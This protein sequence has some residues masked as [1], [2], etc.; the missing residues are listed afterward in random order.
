MDEREAITGLL[1]R[2]HAKHAHRRRQNGLGALQCLGCG[3]TACRAETLV[4]LHAFCARRACQLGFHLSER[5]MLSVDPPVGGK[6]VAPPP[7]VE[8][9]W[10]DYI[11]D[12][13]ICLI[14]LQAFDWAL[15]SVADYDALMA[16]RAVSQRFAR[17]IDDC[18][19]PQLWRLDGSVIPKLSLDALMR[20]RGLRT[21]EYQGNYAGDADEQARLFA[22][23]PA[24]TD[25][26]LAIYG[27]DFGSREPNL[28]ALPP[29]LQRLSLVH[30]TKNAGA[31]AAIQGLAGQLIALRLYDCP[32]MSGTALAGQSALR[33]LVLHG[34]QAPLD[35]GPCVA[36]ETL[37]ATP[38]GGA[39]LET[40]S[41]TLTRLWLSTGQRAMPVDDAWIAAL[42][43][44]RHLYFSGISLTDAGLS[45]LVNLET[46]MLV[47]CPGVTGAS[48]S[49]LTRLSALSLEECHGAHDMTVEQAAPLHRSVRWLAHIGES[50]M[51]WR[52]LAGFTQLTSLDLTGNIDLGLDSA[53]VLRDMLLLESLFLCGDQVNTSLDHLKR[54]RV[55]D[56]S[57]SYGFGNS[58]LSALTTLEELSLNNNSDIT[59]AGLRNLP[60]LHT[61]LLVNNWTVTYAGVAPLWPQLRRLAEFK[62]AATIPDIAYR[63]ARI[64]HSPEAALERGQ[65]ALAAWDDFPYDII[66]NMY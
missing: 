22:A 29:R 11:P 51:P 31:E 28:P 16:M 63:D 49:R 25:L 43:G 52:T 65:R 60:R 17:V 27:Q 61:L 56:L 34:R 20:F 23:L 8:F 45:T 7:E 64:D 21:L 47:A 50:Y 41:A 54:L 2:A 39:R 59:D 44:L 5:L 1:R 24:L 48:L 62:S 33:E 38:L 9:V 46:L 18:V 15:D 55:L 36:L 30:V 19:V 66:R 12:E 53:F 4:P 10:P 37:I 32:G 26:K 3:A 57:E 40:V 42:T 58:R 13:L 35:L 14:V 6:R